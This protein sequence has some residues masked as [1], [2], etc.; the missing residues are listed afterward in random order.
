[1]QPNKPDPMTDLGT[2]TDTELMWL[3]RKETNDIADM[4]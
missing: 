1:M 2:C 3:T 4:S